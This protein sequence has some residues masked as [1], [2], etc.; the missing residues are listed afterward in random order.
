M[1]LFTEERSSGFRRVTSHTN[2]FLSNR[3]VLCS[4]A[5]GKPVGDKASLEANPEVPADWQMQLSLAEKHIATLITGEGS[6]ENLDESN[7]VKGSKDIPGSES[8][9]NEVNNI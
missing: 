3:G 9:E 1:S 2:R 7:K 6:A 8:V 5:T 4:L